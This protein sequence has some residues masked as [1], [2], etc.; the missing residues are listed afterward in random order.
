MRHAGVVE[1]DIDFPEPL[2]YSR[3]EIFYSFWIA[4]VAALFEHGKLVRLQSF[5][6][7]LKRIGVAGGDCQIA[8]GGSQSIGNGK[9]NAP[10]A[11]SDDGNFA[12]ERPHWLGR[13]FLSR[14]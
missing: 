6:G 7:I 13:C 5:C 3:E 11:A 4:D 12:C 8:S 14:H 9:A 10:A 2:F 1:Q